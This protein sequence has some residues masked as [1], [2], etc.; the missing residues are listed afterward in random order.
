MDEYGYGDGLGITIART[1]TR[2]TRVVPTRARIELAK[3]RIPVRSPVKPAVRR[4][5]PPVVPSPVQ[6]PRLRPRTPV[7]P[8]HVQP[9][10][11]PKPRQEREYG[12]VTLPPPIVVDTQGK[13]IGRPYKPGPITKALC[14]PWCPPGMKPVVPTDKSGGIPAIPAAIWEEIRRRLEPKA[15]P[16]PIAPSP[17]SPVQGRPATGTP[18][19]MPPPA[20]KGALLEAGALPKGILPMLLFGLAAVVLFGGE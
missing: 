4:V 1:G 18:V 5:I 2:L 12:D 8:R 13:P 15:K 10:P 14:P 17:P 9:R 20:K 3:R 6:R 7:V 16:V 11:R 19:K